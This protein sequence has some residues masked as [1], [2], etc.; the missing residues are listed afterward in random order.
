MDHVKRQIEARTLRAAA[1]K[2][3]LANCQSGLKHRQLMER[4]VLCRSQALGQLREKRGINASESQFQNSPKTM[5]V[6]N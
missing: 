5:A 6:S 3:S 2:R 4:S 1:A